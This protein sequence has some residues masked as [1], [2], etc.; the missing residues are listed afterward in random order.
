MHSRPNTAQRQGVWSTSL[1]GAA[2][3]IFMAECSKC[4]DPPL[5]RHGSRDLIRLRQLTVTNSQMIPF[6]K[7]RRPFPG[8]SAPMGIRSFFSRENTRSRIVLHP[9]PHRLLLEVLLDIIAIGWGSCALI[10]NLMTEI[11]FF[12]EA[13]SMRFMTQTPT[14]RLA[15]TLCPVWIVSSNA[16]RIQ[17][18]S[19]KLPFS[20]QRC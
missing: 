20:A 17:R 19:V 5:Q 3:I 10:I 1:P 8:L 13:T 7:L 14:V 6:I 15:G 18:N 4:G 12:S 16:A 11:R 2:E 9:S